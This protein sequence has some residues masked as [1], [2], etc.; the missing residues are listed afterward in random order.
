MASMILMQDTALEMGAIALA[1]AKEEEEKGDNLSKNIEEAFNDINKSIRAFFLKDGNKTKYGVSKFSE[2]LNI[3]IRKIQVNGSMADFDGALSNLA[4]KFNA[5][6]EKHN[7]V[8]VHHD[9]GASWKKN[10]ND[11][12]RFSG[13]KENMTNIL[14]IV[15]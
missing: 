4:V 8:S 11:I 5:E 7:A 6:L 9:N 13:M 10:K 15:S 2:A 3:K 12:K 14:K 1:V